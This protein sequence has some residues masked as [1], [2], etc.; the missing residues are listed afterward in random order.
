[1]LSLSWPKKKRSISII[2]VIE[3]ADYLPREIQV[4]GL[5]FIPDEDGGMK[6]MYH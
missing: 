2:A 1:M 4:T 3:K 5:L 6:K